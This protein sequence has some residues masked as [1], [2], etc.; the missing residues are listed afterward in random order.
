MDKLERSVGA[1]AFDGVHILPPPEPERADR[2]TCAGRANPGG[3]VRDTVQITN[4]DELTNRQRGNT[5]D[6]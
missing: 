6:V 5:Y 4:R 1:A 3:G 2:N